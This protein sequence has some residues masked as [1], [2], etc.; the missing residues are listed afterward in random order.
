VNEL[1][2]RLARRTLELVDI[3]S[4][5]GDESALLSGLEVPS[6][7]PLLDATDAVR[8]HGPVARRAGTPLV[9]LVGHVDTVP[10]NGNLPGHREGSDIVGRGAADMKGAIAVMEELAAAIASGRLISDIDVGVLF[11]GREEL[12]ITQSA[13]L[14]L[15][16][17]CATARDADLA[18]VMEPTANAVELG[19]LG[20]LNARAVFH[21]E[22]AHAAR[23]WLGRNAIHEAV[24]ALASIVDAPPRDVE[25]G[26]LVYR[27]VTSVTTIAGGLAANVVPDLVEAH[28]NHRYAPGVSPAHAERR[29]RDLLPGAEVVIVGNAPPGPVPSD[30]ALVARLGRATGVEVRPKQAWT[31]VAEFGLAGIDAVNLGP[32]DPGYAHRDDERVSAGALAW[33]VEVLTA[34]LTGAEAEGGD[35]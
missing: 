24:H 10:A 1:Q 30:N 2:E 8:F 14:P 20:N 22:T 12:P 26:G 4:V 19:C 28:V 7:L 11:F 15:L 3:P 23:P 34:F 6:A 35:P 9:L 16:E 17:R 13:L 21:G 27:E 5:S 29:L 32:G 31:P 18:I 33:C 25:V